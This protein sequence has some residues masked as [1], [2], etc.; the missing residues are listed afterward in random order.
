MNAAQAIAVVYVLGG[1]WGRCG[2]VAVDGGFAAAPPA[3]RHLEWSDAGWPV[4]GG[5]VTP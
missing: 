2:A 1:V 5:W 4:A 3:V